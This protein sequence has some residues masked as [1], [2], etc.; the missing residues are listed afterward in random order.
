MTTSTPMTTSIEQFLH[1]GRTPNAVALRHHEFG[2]W[3]PVTWGQLNESAKALGGGLL[4]MLVSDRDVV[5]LLMENHPQWIAAD[6]AIQGTGATTLAL[7][8]FLDAESVVQ[9]LESSGAIAVL[10]GDQEQFDKVDELRAIGRVPK[11][12][13]IA[14]LDTR[15]VRKL[16]DLAREDRESVLT[17]SQLSNRASA[18]SWNA[19]AAAV[20][21]AQRAVILGG[22]AM[23]HD[24]VMSAADTASNTLA[25]TQNDRLLAQ[26]SFADP[27]ERAISIGGLLSRG[28]Q[29]AIGEGGPL[30]QAELTAVQPTLLHATS[31]FLERTEA[32]LTARIR[33]TKGLRKFALNVGWK[34][35]AVVTKKPVPLLRMIG[36]VSLITVGLFLWFTPKMV[37]PLRLL[38]VLAILV[39]FGLLAVL[40]GAAVTGPLR[41]Q[42]GFARAR[43]VVLSNSDNAKLFLGRLGLVQLDASQFASPPAAIS[44]GQKGSSQ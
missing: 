20:I 33:S 23:T 14:V 7:D 8:P 36:I 11:L 42:L 10:C 39:G 5:G 13:F 28:L 34:A 2:I 40:T 30:A 19:T 9:A 18:N 37:D 4:S 44:A 35:G 6:M 43:V 38:L 24:E 26:A 31:D 21:G 17:F 25:L 22:V 15:G 41:R 27:V 12:E 32:T 29:V 16:D 1:R 3:V